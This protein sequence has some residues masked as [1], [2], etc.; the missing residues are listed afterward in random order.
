MRIRAH[1]DPDLAALAALIGDPSRAAIL[2]ALMDGRALPAGDL[3]RRAGISPQTASAHL[4]RLF[5]GKLLAVEVQGRHHYY[6]LHDER[7]A[8][9][10]EA[11]ATI[12]PA[13]PAR[14]PAQRDAARTL[15][16]ARTCYGHLAGTLGVA[17]TGAI[18]ER[19]YLNEADAGFIVTAAGDRW[20]RDFGIDLDALR[21]QRRPLARRCL[22]WSERRHHLAGALGVAIASRCFDNGWIARVRDSR[23]VRLTDRGREAMRREFSLKIDNLSI[24]SPN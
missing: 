7:V 13:P 8:R 12:A 5:R 17:L 3:A 20:F 19:G 11:M 18:R 6:R 10:V 14:T 15:R 24:S 2:V 1:S 23:A 22:D 9:L 16:F 21:G 4:D